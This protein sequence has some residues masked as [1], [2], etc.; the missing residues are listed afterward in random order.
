MKRGKKHRAPIARA[1]LVEGYNLSVDNGLRLFASALDLIETFP[2][3]VL[4]LAQ[5]GQEEVGKSLS[6]LAAF[7]LRDDSPAWEGFWEGWQSHNLKAHRAFLYEL[8]NPVRIELNLPDGTHFAGQPLR[9]S[10]PREKEAGLYVDFD[11][12]SGSF[13]APASSVTRLEALAR[14]STLCYLGATADATRRALMNADSIF[15]LST[16]GEIALRICSEPLYQQDMPEIL[17]E[18]ED[19]SVRHR[20]LMDDF[21]T[22]SAGTTKFFVDLRKPQEAPIAPPPQ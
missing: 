10:M 9:P 8:L 7:V 16:F 2:D 18:F 17:K 4:A 12:K 21:R 20:A 15:R 3:K 22:A 6:I 1:R 11:E 13:V 14:T 19:R 5:V